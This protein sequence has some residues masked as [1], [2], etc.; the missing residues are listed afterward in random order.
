MRSHGAGLAGVVLALTGCSAGAEKALRVEA[1][2]EQPSEPVETA[3]NAEA[4]VAEPEPFDL[5]R[6]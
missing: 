5:T 6:H 3:E 1:P 4:A 2:V